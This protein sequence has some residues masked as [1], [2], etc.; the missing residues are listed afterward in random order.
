MVEPDYPAIVE[1]F[2]T[3]GAEPVITIPGLDAESLTLQGSI[4][5]SGQTNAYLETTYLAPLRALRG[6]EVAV[7]SP[8]S[9]YDGTWVLIRFTPRRIGEGAF[10]RYTYTLKLVKGLSHNI[11]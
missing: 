11:L 6:T 4:Y 5:V 2:G 10:V 7:T 8:D 9:Q 1:V 3:D